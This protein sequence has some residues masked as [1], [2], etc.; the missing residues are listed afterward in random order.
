MCGFGLCEISRQRPDKTK[1]SSP[2]FRHRFYDSIVADILLTISSVF[3]LNFVNNSAEF[4]FGRMNI[5]WNRLANWC[6][7][8]N[9][10]CNS[11]SW[12]RVWPSGSWRRVWPLCSGGRVAFTHRISS[13]DK[14]NLNI[15]WFQNN[16]FYTLLLPL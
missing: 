1:D 6:N 5:D 10:R 3:A 7:S 12:R 4:L 15:F 8:E 14:I 9:W 2:W 11:G 13:K 16:R